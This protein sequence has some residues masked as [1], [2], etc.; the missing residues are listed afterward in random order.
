MLDVIRVGASALVA[1]GHLTQP[2][3]S[4]GMPALT[5]L[6]RASVAIF[7]V[8]SGFVIRFVTTYK[9]STFGHYLKDRASRIYSVALPALLLTW[10]ADSVSHRVNPAYY[11]TWL[12]PQSTWLQ[13]FTNS[14]F[15]AQ[16]WTL[17]I[18]PLSNSPFWSLNYEVGY[19]V[20]YGC[21]FYLRGY[22]RVLAVAVTMLVLG[23]KILFLFPVWLI[24]AYAY[25]LY[26][27]W[28]EKGVTASRITRLLGAT[29]LALTVFGVVLSLDHP[30]LHTLVQRQLALHRLSMRYQMGMTGGA[31]GFIVF[32]YL[33]TVVFLR[34]LFYVRSLTLARDSPA[35]RWVRFIAEGTFPIYVIHFP[36]YVLI[37][38]CVPY[39]HRSVPQLGAILL[40][41]LTL[42]VLAGH[43]ANLL[44]SRLRGMR[45]R[46]S[47]P[48]IQVV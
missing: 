1:V 20:L 45:W 19:Y 3:F 48:P 11:S 18:S 36:L 6:A 23:P 5:P 14:T 7:F 2:Y 42:G 21:G 9:P 13:L 24:G 27:L 33:G 41:I 26:Q 46:A 22:K 25:D 44:K 12:H 40:L 43:P 47:T 30:L 16:L 15:T 32:A 4:S 31:L 29:A 34:A 39:N 35:V 38:A 37:A 8:L 10:A 28:N 17:D